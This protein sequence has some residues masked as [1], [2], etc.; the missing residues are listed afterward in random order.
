MLPS[1]FS[2]FE[3]GHSLKILCAV[4]YRPPRYNKDFIN[5]FS[6]FLADIV[7]KY[8]HVLIVG[9]FTV[10]VCCPENP[11]AKEFLYLIDSFN[12]VQSVSGPTQE[13]GH[14]LDI[15]LS[16]GL[17]VCNLEICVTQCFLTIGLHCLILLLPVIVTVHWSVQRREHS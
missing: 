3:L 9:D 16:F 17:P 6:D 8:D 2:L 1:S 11:M 4:V 15:V 12:L 5:D 13:C 10:H 7:P 14:T